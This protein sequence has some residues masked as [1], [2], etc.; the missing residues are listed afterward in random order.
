MP[1][2]ERTDNSVLVRRR[3]LTRLEWL[4][5]AAIVALLIALLLPPVQWASSG[6]IDFPVRVLVFDA[7][8]SRPIAGAHVALLRVPSWY[9]EQSDFLKDFDERFTSEFYFSDENPDRGVTDMN[10]QAVITYKFRT[11]ASHQR[12]TPHAHTS[13]VWAAVRAEGYGGAVVQVRQESLPTPQL[14]EQKELRVPI[15]LLPAK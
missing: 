14:R 13:W 9:E 4:V 10:G 1:T 8:S 6:D 3:A 12:P 7:E 5:I 2:T 15:S 11:G